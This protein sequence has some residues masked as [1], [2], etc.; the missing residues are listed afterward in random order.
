MLTNNTDVTEIKNNTVE[1]WVELIVHAN[2][3][4]LYRTYYM[5]VHGTPMV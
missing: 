4:D 2:A 1:S 3:E 5:Y